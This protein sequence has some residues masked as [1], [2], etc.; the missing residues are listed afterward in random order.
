ML[1]G[2][3]YGMTGETS[4]DSGSEELFGSLGVKPLVDAGYNVLT[5]DARG[6]GGS[7]GQVMVDNANFEGRDVQALLTYVA[8]QREAQLDRAGDPRV[9]MTGAS[10]GGGIQLVTA[11]IDRRV[12]AITPVIAWNSLL[13]SLYKDGS[14]KLGLGLGARRGRASRRCPAACSARP[15][16]RWAPPTRG[17]TRRSSRAPRP[18][19]SRRPA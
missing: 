8:N 16:R 13:T 10:Y 2:H 1:L 11:G 3:G 5:W 7:G 17:S 6:F 18:G 15:A 4:R 12:D 14:P 19:A 9:G